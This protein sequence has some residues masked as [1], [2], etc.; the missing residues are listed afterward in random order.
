M[1]F[2][3]YL[4]FALA[5]LFVLGLIGLLA[6]LGRRFNMMPRVTAGRGGPRRLAIVELLSVDAKR[7][8]ALVRRDDVEHLVMLGAAGET[9]IE[10]GITAGPGDARDETGG[11]PEA[12][13]GDAP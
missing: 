9:V 7:R 10:R 12:A 2:D 11:G 13:T 3:D 4:R 8:L 5:L 1:G 6:Y